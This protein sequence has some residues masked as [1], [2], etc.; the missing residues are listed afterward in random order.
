MCRGV[1]GGMGLSVRRWVCR[2]V[3]GLCRG[4][5]GVWVCRGVGGGWGCR[6]SGGVGGWMGVSGRWGVDRG[7]GGGRVR[8][9]VDGCVGRVDW[10][11]GGGE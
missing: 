6:G 7:I 11:V 10:S 8:R 1:S 3:D 2:G 4:G 9:V 5:G